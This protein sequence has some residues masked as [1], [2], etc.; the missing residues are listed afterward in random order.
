MCAVGFV[1]FWAVITYDPRVTD[2]RQFLTRDI[3]IADDT[4]GACSFD[5]LAGGAGGAFANAL[6]E[7]AQL[8][9]IGCV[10]CCF[11]CGMTAEFSVLKEF[12]R[13]F[14]ED[15]E[16]KEACGQGVAGSC[17][18]CYGLCGCSGTDRWLWMGGA[19]AVS[20]GLGSHCRK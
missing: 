10:P 7:L 18:L 8:V 17:S 1:F 3:I 4:E 13:R 15:W 20:N 11:K 14:A 2:V 19:S 9:C 12:T 5:A 16:G 6:T